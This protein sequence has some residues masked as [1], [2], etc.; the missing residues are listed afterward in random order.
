MN[1]QNF[2]FLQSVLIGIWEEDTSGWYW[3]LLPPIMMDDFIFEIN[4]RQILI[5]DYMLDIDN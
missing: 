5:I 4:V 1:W 2:W 3:L